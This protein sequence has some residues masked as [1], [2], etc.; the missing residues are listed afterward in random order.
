MHCARED[1]RLRSGFV[2]TDC[3]YI[4]NITLCVLCIVALRYTSAGKAMPE[5]YTETLVHSDSADGMSPRRDHQQSCQIQI[6]GF[7]RFRGACSVW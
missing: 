2:N 3:K 6:L 4:K 5:R 1:A 7:Q